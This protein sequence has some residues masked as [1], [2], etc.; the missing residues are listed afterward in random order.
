MHAVLDVW[1]ALKRGA[2]AVWE[3]P[4]PLIF[5]LVLTVIGCVT[6]ILAGPLAVAYARLCLRAERGETVRLQELF[7]LRPRFGET[8]LYGLLVIVIVGLGGI[9]GPWLGALLGAAA[10]YFLLWSAWLM[11]DGERSPVVAI[12][13]SAR[14]GIHCW[15][16]TVLL[17]ALF[18][19][20]MTSGFVLVVLGGPIVACAIAASLGSVRSLR[21]A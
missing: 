9:F 10:T 1:D 13:V 5:G 16:T 8:V 19:L 18:E 11:A 20:A 21:A 6:V 15:M 17:F 4:G 3:Q 14:L 2:N 12:A 7:D